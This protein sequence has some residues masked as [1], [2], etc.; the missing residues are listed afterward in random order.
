MPL[1]QAIQLTSRILLAS[2][3]IVF[4]IGSVYRVIKTGATLVSIA[5]TALLIGVAIVGG[6]WWIGLI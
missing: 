3:V 4:V 6:L 1:D 5:I 2:V